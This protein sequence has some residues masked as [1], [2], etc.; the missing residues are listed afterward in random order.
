LCQSIIFNVSALI[1]V[2]CYAF[3][4]HSVLIWTVG[5]KGKMHIAFYT[6]NQ[7]MEHHHDLFT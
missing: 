3:Y 5:H 2:H 6:Y 4:H 1:S 7:P